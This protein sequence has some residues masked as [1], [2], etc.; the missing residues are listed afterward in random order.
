MLAS[1]TLRAP[2]P[3]CLP[4]ERAAEAHRLL[5]S[6]QTTGPLVLLPSN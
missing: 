3:Q 4:L 5:E 2:E 6:G 1:G